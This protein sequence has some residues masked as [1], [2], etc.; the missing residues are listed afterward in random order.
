MSKLLERIEAA[1]KELDMAENAEL[2]AKLEA[3][4]FK[5]GQRPDKPLAVVKLGDLDLCSCGNISMLRAANGVGKS[6]VAAAMLCASIGKEN[7]LGMT[8]ENKG[9]AIYF[10]C[11]QDMYDFY[12]LIEKAGVSTNDPVEAYNVTGFK[13]KEIKESIIAVVE[14]HPD[15]R[16][17]FL[18]GFADIIASVND[19]EQTSE[20]VSWLQDLARENNIAVCGVLHLNPGSDDKSRGHLGSQIE[21]KAEN[22]IQIAVDGDNRIFYLSKPRR[23]PMTKA[24]GIT[25]AWDDDKGNFAVLNKTPE[26]LRLEKKIP[27]RYETAL[28]INKGNWNLSMA[29]KDLVE[30]IQLADKCSKRTASTR[31]NEMVD[32]GL[33]KAVG[34]PGNYIFYDYKNG[35][36]CKS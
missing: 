18:D 33:L 26:Q 21:R 10:D 19:E 12:C 32:I 20:L 7:W 35:E 13:I 31:L 23:K 29:Y 36:Q 2:W 28:K 34:L 4:K 9:R 30:A 25:F 14:M 11:E 15:A 8:S 1:E 5:H 3:R 27:D 22:V 17:L 16:F 24:M 6:H